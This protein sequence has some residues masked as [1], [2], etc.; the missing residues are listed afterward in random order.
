MEF[1]NTL[2]ANAPRDPRHRISCEITKEDFQRYWR[3]IKERTSSSLSGLHYGHY[4]AAATEDPLSEIHALFTQLAVTGASPLA[5]WEKGLSCMLEKTAGVI[6]VEKLRAILLMEADFNFFNGLMFAGRMMRQAK[7]QGRI[8]LEIYGSRKNHEAVEVA[9]N[10]R[11]VA[12]LLRQKRIPGAIASVDAESCYDRIA[13]VAG[14]L[15]AQNW[16]VDPEA[17][18]AMLLTIQRMKYF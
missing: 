11:L 16:D 9:I 17:I 14:S 3:R 2:Q 18:R 7:A 13:H 5:R 4:K 10:R 6:R 15:C 12:D 8:P 1:I